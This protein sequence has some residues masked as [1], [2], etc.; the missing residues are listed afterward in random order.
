VRPDDF[1]KAAAE[2]QRL[3][4]AY[5]N[6][7]AVRTMVGVYRRAIND[8]A[9]ARRDFEKAL[10]MEP[11]NLDAI[12]ELV[13]LDLSTGRHN[14]A[15]H[16][17]RERLRH[18]PNDPP[19]LLLA[20]KTALAQHQ[21]AE[22]ERILRHLIKVDGANIEAYTLLGQVYIAAGKI[23]AAIVEFNAIV[24]RDPR[25]ATAHTMLGLLW[26][27]KRRLPQALGHYEKA[28]AADPRSATA[29]NNLAWV[30]AENDTDLDRAMSLAQ[31]AKA[32]LPGNPEILD[33]LGWVYVKRAMFPLAVTSFEQ[34]VEQAPDNPTYAYHLGLAHSKLGNDA[35]ARKSL[36]RA[37][38]IDPKFANAE[39][40][41]K[42]LAT[43]VY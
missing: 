42:I 33:T 19:L 2:I 21:N 20:A 14:E 23:D 10:E 34:A 17:I 4:Q 5:P 36:E 28:F 25:S 35:K 22:A 37:L 40:A 43:L 15:R 7:P 32:Q 6:S 16:L 26:H 9:G 27:T 8:T 31:A 13:T 1:P 30:L 18:R 41:R 29:A 3:L 39:D 38:K 11:N 24:A 12:V